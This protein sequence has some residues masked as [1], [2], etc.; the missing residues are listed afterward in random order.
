[1]KLR[2]LVRPFGTIVIFVCAL[3]AT[4]ASFYTSHLFND[5]FYSLIGIIIACITLVFLIKESKFP[6]TRVTVHKITLQSLNLK[7]IHLHKQK[8]FR[9][10]NIY[11]NVD[12]YKHVSVYL[13]MLFFSYVFIYQLASPPT[14]LSLVHAAW[15]SLFAFFKINSL[16]F[17]MMYIC[18]LLVNFLI[19]LKQRLKQKKGFLSS[20]VLAFYQTPLQITLALPLTI[21][22][23]YFSTLIFSNTILITSIFFP[24]ITGISID[25]NQI[26]K[27]INDSENDLMLV[28]VSDNASKA[29]IANS[30]IL[31]KKGTF[32]SNNF[33]P[34]I[35]DSFFI[36]SKSL[37]KSVF[38]VND[39]IYIKELDKDIIST[40]SPV[41]AKKIVRKNLTP[42]YI[43]DEPDVQ[44]ISRQD[45]LKYREE[46][47]NKQ[48][49][50]IAGYI[51]ELNKSLNVIAYNINTAKNNISTLQNNISLNTQYRDEEYKSCMNATYTYYGFYE[52]YTYRSYT[53]AY[54][55]SLWDKR[56]RE[57]AGYEEELKVQK[58]NLSYYQSQ[59][60]EFKQY[61]DQFKDYK[62]FIEATKQ[63][64]PYELGLFEPSRSVKVV[65]DAVSDKD[66]SNFMVTLVHEYMHYT[67]FVSD[68]RILP[69]FF[70]EGLTEHF[71][72]KIMSNQLQRETNLGYPLISK[73]ISHMSQ[74]IP[75]KQLEDV[76][77]TKS[78]EQLATLLD[79]AY[80]KDF[81]EDSKLYFALI[82]L[83][84]L[85]ESLKFANNIMFKIGGPELEEKDA[86]S[87]F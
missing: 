50:D 13:L 12:I 85:E 43:K 62:Q 52:N 25:K 11:K 41:L 49:D 70:E 72:R 16:W 61:T 34:S 40:I 37:A 74:K 28:G 21:I 18:I 35:P 5:A 77:F 60:S 31:G 3:S 55:Q 78:E 69:Q 17:F 59:Y 6:L 67:S 83:S 48:I 57:N 29:Y 24:Q 71:A 4:G 19:L 63:Q 45:Y 51:E 87:T 2:R 56:N 84:P 30:S 65:L 27:K 64:T 54:C 14:N 68:E 76:Y 46:Q 86:F 15:F 23:I 81:Y 44:I 66:I 36:K 26:K 79:N 10:V 58:N 22:F 38:M 32:Y 82:P 39:V 42:R 20:L 80:G 7:H 33:I 75:L 8:I 47:I 9:L 1:M 73:I 53:D